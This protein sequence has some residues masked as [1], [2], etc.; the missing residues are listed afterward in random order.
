MESSTK[1]FRNR[2]K[3][4]STYVLFC[5]L[6][7]M[8]GCGKD[9]DIFTPTNEIP[10]LTGNIN[11]FY[12]Y[13]RTTI[14]SEEYFVNT[15]VESVVSTKSGI[16]FIIPKLAFVDS[17]QNLIKGEIK[18]II[19]QLSK[20]SDFIKY[21]QFSNTSSIVLDWYKNLN[22]EGY[23]NGKKVSLSKDNSITIQIPTNSPLSSWKIFNGQ[24]IS[25]RQFKITPSSYSMIKNAI[26]KDGG[27]GTIVDG[28]EFHT[29][30][31]GWLCIASP[32]GDLK[33]SDVKVVLPVAFRSFNTMVIAVNKTSNVIYSFEDTKQIESIFEQKIHDFNNLTFFAA[34]DQK[35]AF[36]TCSKSFV[37]FE[38]TDPVVL[39]PS[40]TPLDDIENQL[41]KL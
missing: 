22:I 32:L 20:K 26:W 17:S 31:L 15:E 27:S 34:S 10:D 21:S 18:I 35:D 23:Y 40:A 2:M 33:Y 9:T 36:Y 13:T 39:T 3:Q 11:N 1:Y 41:N 29:N 38:N 12:S 16:R 4:F 25:T 24:Y 7:V 6:M 19:T 28:I 14:P 37:Q 5:C 8:S 30:I